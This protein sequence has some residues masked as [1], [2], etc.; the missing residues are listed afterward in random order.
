MHLLVLFVLRNQKH[1]F[2]PGQLGDVHGLDHVV[3]Y[4]APVS[5]NYHGV[6]AGSLDLVPEQVEQLVL[7]DQ[8]LAEI[9][10]A[11]T[12]NINNDVR[13]DLRFLAFNLRYDNSDTLLVNK[14]TRQ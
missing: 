7:V 10:P 12:G 1:G 11:V 8:A 3:V 6:F 14:I 9:E 4:D 2:C 13:G 5:L